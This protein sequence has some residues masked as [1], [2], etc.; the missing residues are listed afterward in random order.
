MNFLY[1][2]L[3]TIAICTVVDLLNFQKSNT[4]DYSDVERSIIGGTPV[5]SPNTYPWLVAIHYD[6]GY[7]CGGS[8]L[9]GNKLMTAAH[10]T[11]ESKGKLY[12]KKRFTV[13]SHRYNFKK[14]IEE[15]KS[16]VYKVSEM[17]VHPNYVDVDKGYDVA[18]WKLEQIS[19]NVWQPN[20]TL[21][22][23]NLIHRHQKLIVAGWGDKKAGSGKG[24]KK[25]MQVILPITSKK[26]CY[27]IYPELKHIPSA[28]CAGYKR[29]GV[30]SCQGDSGGPLFVDTG[31][32]SAIVAGIVSY[33]VECAT[34]PGV[35]TKVSE[36]R[37]WVNS[38]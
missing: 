37:K 30:D 36:V 31:N 29:G 22:D 10:C 33:G 25:L 27:K 24:S 16:S 18:V 2:L 13:Y 12:P 19:G 23:G 32:G 14:S 7:W 5:G 28:F 20:V 3:T 34:G 6:N 35:Y 38:V 15:E 21:D 11:L 17:V 26:L 8:L 9:E 1:L 4:L